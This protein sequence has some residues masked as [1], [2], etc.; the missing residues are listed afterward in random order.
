M[1]CPLCVPGVWEGREALKFIPR[2]DVPAWYVASTAVPPL[3]EALPV[4]GG[5]T[6]GPPLPT[7]V[8]CWGWP[9][10]EPLVQGWM[11]SLHRGAEGVQGSGGS[12][13]VKVGCREMQ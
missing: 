2:L 10:P 8:D 6:L 5:E 1:L 3:P 12:S 13:P 4:K 11:R 7:Q 9:D